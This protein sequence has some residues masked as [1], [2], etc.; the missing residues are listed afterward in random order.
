MIMETKV[1]IA[2]VPIHLAN[3]ID[4]LAEHTE[5]T[6]AWIIKQALETWMALEEERHRMTLEALADVDAGHIIDHDAV[7]A[8]ANSL[9]TKKPKSLPKK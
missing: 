1:I 9:S 5:R 2:H 7:V 3:R 4:K 8:W 6:R